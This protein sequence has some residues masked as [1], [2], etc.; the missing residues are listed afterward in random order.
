M[1]HF[2]IDAFL[3]A[4]QKRTECPDGMPDG[5]T[6]DKDGQVWSA[7]WDGG[8]IARLRSDGS[9]QQRISLPTR[10]VSS[11]IFGGD[12]YRDIYVTTAGGHRKNHSGVGAGGLFRIRSAVRGVPEFF[13]RVGISST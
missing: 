2:T 1:A 12:D 5:A 11:L 13:S 3:R 4:S 6:V 10:Q 7:F 9:A 8:C